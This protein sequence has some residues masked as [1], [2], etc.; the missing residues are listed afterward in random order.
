MRV[1]RSPRFPQPAILSTGSG[2]PRYRAGRM[3]ILWPAPPG[4]ERRPR[5]RRRGRRRR[6]APRPPGRPWVLANMIASADGSATDTGGPLGRP[7]RARPT[8]PCSPPSAAVA[9]VIVAGAATVIDRGLRPQPPA[10]P[11]PRPARSPGAS[12][13]RRA[14]RSTSASLAIEPTRRFFAEAPPDARPLVLTVASADPAR[15]R[16]L[17]EVADVHVVGDEQVDWARAFALL[18]D[19]AGR[20]RRGVRGRAASRSASSW[21]TT[22]STSCASRWPRPGGGHRTAHRPRPGARGRPPLTRSP[23]CV[24]ADGNLFLRYAA[25]PAEPARAQCR[26]GAVRLVSSVSSRSKSARSSN[27][28]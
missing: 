9:D 26:L 11:R 23:A 20:P 17:E 7:R 4:G 22:C 6:P 28:L 24:A 12:R 16:A 3:R 14:S 19:E 2:R 27:P 13:R 1:E 25:R 15:R 10:G 21:P 8:R 5:S 18:H